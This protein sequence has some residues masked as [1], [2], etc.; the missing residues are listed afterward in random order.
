MSIGRRAK[1]REGHLNIFKVIICILILI[2]TLSFIAI[3]LS[4]K[5][6]TKNNLSKEISNLPEE[7]EDEQN[8]FVSEEIIANEIETNENLEE[9][10]ED[11]NV[12]IWNGSSKEPKKENN[13]YSIYTPEELKWIADQ[14]ITGEKNFKG[15][16]VNL[17]VDINLGGKANDNGEWEGNTWTPIIGTLESNEEDAQKIRGF[18]GTFNGNN[19]WIK[20]MY[21]NTTENY[22]GFIG[23][24]TGEIKDLVIKNSYIK[25]NDNV[26]CFVG[27][28]NGKISNCIL[29]N[30]KIEGNN[31]VGGFTGSS[32]TS[33]YISCCNHLDCT[34]EILGEDYIG[35]IVG[36]ANNN[37]DLF[38]CSN[39]ANVTGNKY[40]GGITG[41]SFF[42]TG[43]SG[44][45]NTSEKIIGESYIGGISGYSQAQI[46]KSFNTSKIEGKNFL[47]GITGLN[48]VM[49]NISSSYNKG[50]IVGEDDFIGGISGAN[51]ATIVST[52]NTG[53]VTSNNKD[54]KNI[55]GICGQNLSESAVNN[56]YN[57][58]KIDG[59]GFI[60][61]ITGSNFGVQ[62][63]CYYLKD[64]VLAKTEEAKSE[65]EMKLIDLNED[66][67]A[68]SLMI[69]KGY[70]ILNWQ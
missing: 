43:I 5:K 48:Y 4:D 66:F 20:G 36:Y 62:N 59:K 47:G 64:T 40:V 57:I 44:C 58:G 7:I 63:N 50:E 65:E 34:S 32:M 29:V 68:D 14:V 8:D 19:H 16:T 55:G 69:N 1:C 3:T 13:V 41:I 38:S 45:S 61:G 67:K 26:G 28:N 37:I 23:Y 15:S 56:S 31:K 6:G 11:K 24:L 60:G 10:V 2:A 70:L 35:G 21:I 27:L 49:G 46:E 9:I 25:G 51:N 17:M 30:T 53:N 22:A 39:K 42:G 33:S 54:E 52:Y 18:A 12:P